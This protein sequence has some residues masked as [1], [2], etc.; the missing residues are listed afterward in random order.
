M[1]FRLL[2]AVPLLLP[3]LCSVAAAEGSLDEP[4]MEAVYANDVIGA[5]ALLDRGANVEA[6]GYHRTT[7]LVWA[8]MEGNVPMVELLLS[9]GAD[10][11][12]TNALGQNALTSGVLNAQIVRLLLAAGADVEAG[13]SLGITPLMAAASQGALPIVELLLSKGAAVKARST[14]GRG[15]LHFALMANRKRALAV[16]EALHRAGAP[17]DA[18]DADGVTLLMGA[19]SAGHAAIMRTLIGNRVKVWARDATGRTALDY[20]VQGTRLRP[21]A[22]GLLLKQQ[23]S[24][25]ALDHA[26]A[27]AAKVGNL[28]AMAILMA[29][30]ARVGADNGASPLIAAVQGQSWSAARMLLLKGAPV[31]WKS[32][33]GLIALHHAVGNGDLEL[34]RLLLQYGAALDTPDGDGRTP[35]VQAIQSDRT[36]IVELLLAAGADP[37]QK[38]YGSSLRQI[39]ALQGNSNLVT[40]MD[41]GSS[42]RLKRELGVDA[43][44]SDRRIA[45]QRDRIAGTW[46]D[47]ENALELHLAKEGRFTRSV[48]LFVVEATDRGRWSVGEGDLVLDIRE[49]AEGNPRVQRF[50]IIWV[51]QK[52]LVLDASLSRVHLTRAD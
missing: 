17:T 5:K 45:G 22:V 16:F 48:A 12:A 13:D 41:R 18:V 44:L 39:A 4:L 27:S 28:Q 29:A 6:L 3:A 10:V 32:P 19:A 21:G 51:D 20:A 26:L 47:E 31:N 50:P 7:P 33:E 52:S 23:P 35:L 37:M 30:G 49:P 25:P 36:D 2:A 15:V 34:V 8:A 11:K 43:P 24:R 46:R 1:R 42:E 38:W 40:M 9:R 14:D